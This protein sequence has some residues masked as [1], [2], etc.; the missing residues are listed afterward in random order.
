MNRRY[1]ADFGN[2]TDKQHEANVKE[3][4]ETNKRMVKIRAEINAMKK[5]DEE[6]CDE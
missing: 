1:N 4:D 6:Q 3:L 2:I 5:Q